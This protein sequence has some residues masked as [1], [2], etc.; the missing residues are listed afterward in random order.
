MFAG[1]RRSSCCKDVQSRDLAVGRPGRR[2]RGEQVL[3]DKVIGTVGFFGSS[4]MTGA[5]CMSLGEAQS[6]VWG[7]GE[8]TILSGH[9]EFYRAMS[10][11][12]HAVPI[13]FV[14][15]L[16]YGGLRFNRLF[17]QSLPVRPSAAMPTLP[18]EADDD[19]SCRA[20]SLNMT[21]CVLFLR[22]CLFRL[23]LYRHCLYCL[24]LS[25]LCLFSS[26][27]FASA[28]SPLFVLSSPVPSQPVPSLISSA[29]VPSQPVL[30]LPVLPF[31]FRLRLFR[32]CTSRPSAA[33]PKYSGRSDLP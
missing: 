3:N 13:R 5:D 25:C 18:G 7:G 29:P 30:S 10:L 31:L 6:A 4:P 14:V 27:C 11:P 16:S 15:C 28:C 24:F 21:A 23:R 12:L 8:L 26:V 17:T 20:S 9:V 19:H 22:F 33:H 2:R 1:Q 32:L